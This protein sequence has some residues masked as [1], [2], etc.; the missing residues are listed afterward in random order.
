MMIAHHN[1]A[2]DMAREEQANGENGDAKSL[3]ATIERSQK[4]E[5][6]QM[7]KILDRL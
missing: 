3:A 6:Q 1:G 7:Q 5:V 4:T 2:I